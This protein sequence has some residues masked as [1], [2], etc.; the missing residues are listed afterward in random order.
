M[1]LDVDVQ[2]CDIHSQACPLSVQSRPETNVY[3]DGK[4]EIRNNIYLIVLHFSVEITPQSCLHSL[5]PLQF[6]IGY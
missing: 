6:H 1:I 5:Y 3:E 2:V 4:F